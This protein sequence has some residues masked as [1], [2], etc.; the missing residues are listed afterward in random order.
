[1][2]SLSWQGLQGF[3]AGL[4]VY[5][6][7]YSFTFTATCTGVGLIIGSVVE[8]KDAGVEGNHLLIVHFVGLVEWSGPRG[9]AFLAHFGDK[10]S[11]LKGR[12]VVECWSTKI[13]G[14]LDS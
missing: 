8:L 6:L 5:H 14:H 4:Q 7:P 13:G 2:L 9:R 1:M 10:H 11:V 12:F 3:K